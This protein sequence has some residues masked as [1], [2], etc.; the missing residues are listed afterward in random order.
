[1]GEY[2]VYCE[3]QVEAVNLDVEHIKPQKAHDKL[4]LT[5][6]NFLLACKSC[7]TYKRHY[8][9]AA[10]QSS[11]LSSQAWPH[12][13]NTYA[14]YAY[15]QHG[16]IT[17]SL[18]ITAPA[19]REMATRTLRMAGLDQTPAVDVAYK[20]LSLIYDITSRRERAWR[21]ANLALKAYEQNATDIQRLSILDQAESVGFFSIWM[22][23]FSAHLLVK[24]SLVVRFKACTTCFDLNSDP[25]SPRAPGRI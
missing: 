12:L 25:L 7:N 13:D 4:S 14:A 17:V 6:A 9:G 22:H 15:D 16:R 1:M 18:A 2:C 11:I 21:I 8:Q 10:R 3:R 20:K 5:W 23:I 19:Q 24:Q